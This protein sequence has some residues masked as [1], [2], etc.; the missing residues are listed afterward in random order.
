MPGDITDE[1][2][3]VIENPGETDNGFSSFILPYKKYITE[4][5]AF[6]TIVG[7]AALGLWSMIFLFFAE[8]NDA[9][10]TGTKV[11]FKSLIATIIAGLIAWGLMHWLSWNMSLIIA[12]LIGL[13]FFISMF[14]QIGF[15]KSLLII[16]LTFIVFV[17]I[18]AV[19]ILLL[20]GFIVNLEEFFTIIL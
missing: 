3:N 12:G 7:L 16:I 11:F 14:R 8:R 20:R 6:W 19:G 10:L 17:C 15:L 1:E 5:L 4:N 18:W 9:S 13:I 2:G